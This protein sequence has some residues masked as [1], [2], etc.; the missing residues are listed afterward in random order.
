L[1]E[2]TLAGRATIDG[3]FS[4]GRQ[5]KTVLSRAEDGK[6]IVQV[7]MAVIWEVSILARIVRINVR[8]SVRAFFDDLFSNPAFQPFDLTPAQVFPADDLRFTRDAFDGLIARPRAIGPGRHHARHRHHR[9]RR[10]R[11]GLVVV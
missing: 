1:S 3:P 10:R 4:C 8:R 9:V 5:A 6:V 7:P 11:D 2:Q